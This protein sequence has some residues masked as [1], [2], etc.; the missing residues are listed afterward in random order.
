MALGFGKWRSSGIQG[1]LVVGSLLTTG[2]Q[3]GVNI[4]IQHQ[5]ED[6]PHVEEDAG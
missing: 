5:H 3:T 4:S 6:R 1:N 2:P